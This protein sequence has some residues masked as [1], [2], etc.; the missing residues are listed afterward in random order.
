MRLKLGTGAGAALAL[1]VLGA[2]RP[3]P[4]PGFTLL[5]L[6][7]SPTAH[8]GRYTWA[9]DAPHSRLIAFDGDLHVVRTVT[10]PRLSSP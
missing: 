10:D 6:G 1:A 4:P 2:C 3:G 9:P 7:R 5:F 8:V